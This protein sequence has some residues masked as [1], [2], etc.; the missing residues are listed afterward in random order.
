MSETNQPFDADHVV[1]GPSTNGT[2]NEPEIRRRLADVAATTTL[3]E[4]RAWEQIQQRLA[5]PGPH[6]VRPLAT[7][8]VRRR[9]AAVAAVVILV[10]GALLLTR[11]GDDRGR[12][13]TQNSTT[14]TERSAT[15]STTDDD[16]STTTTSTTIRPGDAPKAGPGT[17]GDPRTGPNAT[18]PGGGPTP[19]SSASGSGQ[20]GGGGTGMTS[21]PATSPSGTTPTPGTA[22][23]GRAPAVTLSS[24]AYTA[25]ATVW[26]DG[27]GYY[28][29]LWAPEPDAY[30][31]MWSW[32]VNEGQN[33]LEGQSSVLTGTD[34]QSHMLVW[35]LVR[36]DAAAVRI[37]TTGGVSSTAALGSTA[38]PGLRPWIGES[39]PGQV[40]RAEALDGA[41]NVLHT[42]TAPGWFATPETC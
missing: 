20:G 6:P 10:I 23:D 28:M 33:C 1:G 38:L 5:T 2:A 25:Q 37:V 17:G 36:A 8:Q 30:L 29:N 31:N 13:V 32:A 19:G 18:T 21:P 40:D 7:R 35:G 14:T 26:I 24:S 39:P 12:V 41:G 15:T 11:D 22:P 34:G 16:G 9:R 27:G 3:D 4:D 42:A